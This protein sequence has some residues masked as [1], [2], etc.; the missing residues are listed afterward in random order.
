MKF[1]YVNDEYLKFLNLKYDDKVMKPNYTGAK[2]FVFGLVLNIG[3]IHYYAPVSSI[4]RKKSNKNHLYNIDKQGNI[5]Y[6]ALKPAIKPRVFPIHDNHPNGEV[7]AMVRLDFMFPIHI[8]DI[9]EV[10]F[11]VFDTAIK[12][13]QEYKILLEKEF[14][15]CKKHYSVICEKANKVYGK[16]KDPKHIFSKICCNFNMLEIGFKEWIK[17]KNY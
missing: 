3:G 15:T 10:N 2:K 1:Y 9:N 4:D 11:K 7:I 6:S 8:N 12:S 14:E 13:D 17:Q 5:N 16:S